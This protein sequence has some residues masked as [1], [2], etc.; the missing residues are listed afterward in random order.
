[1]DNQNDDGLIIALVFCT[2]IAFGVG[3]GLGAYVTRGIMEPAIEMAL[4]R[5]HITI[6]EPVPDQTIFPP[7]TVVS[8]WYGRPYHRRK[9]ADGS[10][11]NMYEMTV[12]HPWLPFGTHLLLEND[13]NGTYCIV[14]VTDRGP[15][16]EGRMLDVS[17]AVAVRL[18]MVEVGIA[19]L[20]A[21]VVEFPGVAVIGRPSVED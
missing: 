19:V 17:Y 14:T 10:I 20:K 3:A 6:I 12:A 9:A 21:R 1:M 2:L 16:I 8:S 4:A 18:G 7:Q 5:P 11:Y 15:F 13:L